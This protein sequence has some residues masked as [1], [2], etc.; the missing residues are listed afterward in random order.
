MIR[1]YP[2]R[3]ES[4]ARQAYPVAAANRDSFGGEI[5]RCAQNGGVGRE[6]KH[7]QRG[8]GNTGTKLAS[9]GPALS[10]PT[11]YGGGR[12]WNATRSLRAPSRKLIPLWPPPDF[13][14]DSRLRGNDDEVRRGL[15]RG[16]R[17]KR[18]RPRR[19]YKALCPLRF[20]VADRQHGFDIKRV[21]AEP[22][23]QR[24]VN[25]SVAFRFPFN[26]QA[27]AHAFLQR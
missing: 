4:R 26:R 20:R 7:S 9:E 25:P 17:R 24:R 2:R 5:P 27:H 8:E 16:R 21:N 3:R 19:D 23:A 13:P 10:G 6:Q 18:A 14:L 11:F 22:R 15:R 12:H 1:S